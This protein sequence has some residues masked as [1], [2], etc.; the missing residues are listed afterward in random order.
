MS[1]HNIV[2]LRGALTAEAQV[3][4][5]ASGQTVAQFDVTTRDEDGAQ[6]VPVAWHEPP[7]AGVPVEPGEDLVVV[8]S[9]RRRFFRAGGST[10]SR[11][12]VLAAQVIAA[13]RR[14]EVGRALDGARRALE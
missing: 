1:G 13:R 7:T 6:T 11:T 9:V 4:V 12:E 8:G 2:V 10:Q 3:R 5:L 14:R